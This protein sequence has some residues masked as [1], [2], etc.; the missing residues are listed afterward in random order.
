VNRGERQGMADMVR[1]RLT[2]GARWQQGPDGQWRGV[3]ESEREHDS[4][5]MGR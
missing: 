2:G 5:A 3:G 4:A 1:E